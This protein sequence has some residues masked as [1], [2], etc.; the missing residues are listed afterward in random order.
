MSR[1]LP[2]RLRPLWPL[3]KRVQLLLTL[4]LGVP[5]R[6]VARLVP[7]GGPWTAT[8]SATDTTTRSRLGALVHHGGPAEH[9]RRAA[10]PGSPDGHP[11]FAAAASVDIPAHYTLELENGIAI[12]PMGANATGDGILDYA[13]SGYFGV[14][15][16]RQHPVFLRPRMT[17]PTR[18]SGTVLHLNT[19]GAATNYY[20][21]LFDALPR[22]GVFRECL[23]EHQI[24]AVILPHSAGYQRQL[25]EMMGLRT[26]LIDPADG[27]WYQADRLLVPSTPNESISCPH[28]VL[29]WVRAT[30][31][32]SRETRRRRRLYISRGDEPNTR[33]FLHEAELMVALDKWNFESIDPGKLTVQE[34]INTFADA[35]IVVGAHGAGLTNIAFCQK[36]TSVIELFA[37]D[38]VHLGLWSIAV[39][40]GLDYRYIVSEGGSRPSGRQMKPFQDV[41]VPVEIVRSAVEACLEG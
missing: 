18:V 31:P 23:P 15:H 7:V 25:I 10:P 27:T 33:R 37:K 22:F 8:E 6:M 32:P 39:A 1:N 4:V 17:R 12:G 2:A 3:L 9:L 34:Q 24:D 16:W 19:R 29:D 11:Q 14:D 5:N 41:D 36:D 13:T 30:F 20:H 35:E 28:W 38:Y 40:A 26:D 21:F